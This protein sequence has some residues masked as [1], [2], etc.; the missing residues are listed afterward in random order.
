MRRRATRRVC[1]R[2]KRAAVW[3]ALAP[4]AAAMGG[5]DGPAR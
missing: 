1:A 3:V 4:L 2:V 5:H